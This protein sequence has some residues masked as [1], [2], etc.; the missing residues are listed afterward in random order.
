MDAAVEAVLPAAHRSRCWYH[1]EQNL[2]HNLYSDLTVGFDDF[3]AA[4]KAAC[5]CETEEEHMTGRLRLHSDYPAAVSYL[6]KN[7]WPNAERFAICY[8]KRWCTLGILS[9]QRVEGMN[10]KL[11]GALKV[12][13]RTELAVLFQTLEYAASDIDR[14]AVATM[15]EMDAVYQKEA[16]R[17]TLKGQMHPFISGFAQQ[18]V[19]QQADFL[20][21]YRASSA[22]IDGVT[23][24]TVRHV[25]RTESTHIVK[26]TPDSMSCSCCFPATYLLPCRHVLC[27]NAET[28]MKAFVHTQVGKRWLRSFKPPRDYR[29]A[30]SLIAAVQSSSSSPAPAAPTPPLPTFL[31]TISRLAAARTE[32]QRYGTL[33]GL[34]KTAADRGAGDASAYPRVLQRT[35]EFVQWVLDETSEGPPVRV[36]ASAPAAAP[37]S[38]SLTSLNPG[39]SIEEVVEPQK[40]K[41]GGSGKEKR[42]DSQ[43]Q[44]PRRKRKKT[45]GGGLSMTQ[46]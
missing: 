40:P 45:G 31:S 44:R 38:R 27:L 43:G 41:K 16:Y 18:K 13:S 26:A 22:V 6:E 10:A 19:Q 17:E 35:Q 33:M 25:Q 34:L 32:P 12:N 11:K 46:Q 30:L 3:L 23:V 1:L 7:T 9:T 29:P 21:N 24:W 5:L 14:K 20:H 15:L 4:W 37:L 2:R 42:H 8:T 39:T 28:M 36:E